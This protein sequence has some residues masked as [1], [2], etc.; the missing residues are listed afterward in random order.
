MCPNYVLNLL[1][2]TDTVLIWNCH[3]I[4][5]HLNHPVCVELMTN[6]S[7][8][9]SV[10]TGMTTHFKLDILFWVQISKWGQVVI[11]VHVS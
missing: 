6:I 7:E 8:T 4:R 1:R 2:N 3:S 5:M 9:V 10:G 11:A